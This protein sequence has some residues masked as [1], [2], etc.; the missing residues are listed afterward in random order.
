[1]CYIKREFAYSTDKYHILLCICEKNGF[2]WF[3]IN[4]TKVITSSI[5]LYFTFKTIIFG[6]IVSF[7]ERYN[8]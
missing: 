2:L 3:S 7:D 6:L 4:L 5:D 8:E 1:M